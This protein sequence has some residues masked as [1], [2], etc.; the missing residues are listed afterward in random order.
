MPAILVVL[1][2]AIGGILISAHR[3]ALV[4]LAAQVARFEARGDGDLAASALEEWE[5]SSVEVVRSRH[6]GL[7]CVTLRS[8]PGGGLLAG[9]G[10]ES[11]ACAAISGETATGS[12]PGRETAE[13]RAAGG[14]ATD[15]AVVPADEGAG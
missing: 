2:L 7:H 1:G 14:G 5:G 12:A 4:S 8:Q 3:V 13:G 10:I 9:I 15:E 11:L 6:R